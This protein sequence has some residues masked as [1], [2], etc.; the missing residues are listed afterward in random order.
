MS[1]ARYYQ[2]EDAISEYGFLAKYPTT[3]AAIAC[4]YVS[5]SQLKQVNQ[6]W[7]HIYQ[8][9]KDNCSVEWG[10]ASPQDDLMQSGITGVAEQQESNVIKI[11]AFLGALSVCGFQKK[12]AAKRASCHS[13]FLFLLIINLSGRYKALQNR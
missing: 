1:V 9:V 10:G 7:Y 6:C 2:C 4:P 8:I 12:P 5:M 13:S 3:G 11:P